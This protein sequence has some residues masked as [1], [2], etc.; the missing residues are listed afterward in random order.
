MG[1]FAVTDDAGIGIGFCEILQQLVEGVL[2]GF[3]TLI[4]G[5]AFLIKT[6]SFLGK[7]PEVERQEK[8]K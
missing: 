4:S 1:Q 7:R 8:M 6:Y 5:F 2:L 3:S